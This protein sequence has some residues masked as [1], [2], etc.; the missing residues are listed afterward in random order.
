MA[1]GR[2]SVPLSPVFLDASSQRFFMRHLLEAT[3]SYGE[4]PDET[5]KEH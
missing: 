5:T 2:S 3:R 1:T 4:N